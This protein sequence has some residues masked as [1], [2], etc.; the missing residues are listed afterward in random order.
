MSKTLTWEPAA[1]ARPLRATLLY[2]LATA[3]RAGSELA[4][5]R[6]QALSETSEKTVA[7]GSMEFHSLHG[8]AGAPRG[9]LYVDGVLVGVIE[10][11]KR[12]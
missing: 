2:L 6:A 9:A 10:G 5:R 8:D 4:T 11:V 7:A 3:L 12:L 1:T